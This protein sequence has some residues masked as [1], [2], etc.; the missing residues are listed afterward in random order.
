MI[1]IKSKSEIEKMRQGGQILA[2]IVRVLGEKAQAGVSTL[3]IDALAEKLIQEA[4][5]EPSFK[6]YG[7][8]TGNPFPA[9]ICAS[10]NHEVVHGIPSDKKLRSGDLLKIDIGMKHDGFHTDMARMF[11]VDEVSPEARKLM[12]VTEKSFWQGIK[13]L[14]A[15]IRMSQYSKAVQQYVEGEGFSVVRNLVGHGIGEE[16]HEDPQIPNYF[17]KKYADLE[18]A[19]GMVL[20]LEPMVNTGGYQTKIGHDGWVFVTSDGSLSGHYENTIVITEKG[21]EVLTQ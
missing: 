6:G 1:K 13:G 5:G 14:R 7:A 12:E 16:V 2:G 10:L 4:G 21:V 19:S 17:N 15:G 9:V 18:L 11:A 20:A 3:E 8:E